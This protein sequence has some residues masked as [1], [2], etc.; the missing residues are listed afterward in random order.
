MTHRGPYSSAHPEQL[1]QR[2]RLGLS[3]F[4]PGLLLA[5]HGEVF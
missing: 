3:Q 4:S 1:F 2:L 5:G